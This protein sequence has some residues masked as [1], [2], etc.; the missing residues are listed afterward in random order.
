MESVFFCSKVSGGKRLFLFY[1]SFITLLNTI[2][3]QF[4]TVVGCRHLEEYIWEV[5][6]GGPN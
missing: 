3:T 2:S 1:L 5:A 6:G 4:A